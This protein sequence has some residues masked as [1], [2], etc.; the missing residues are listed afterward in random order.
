MGCNPAVPGA[1]ASH[2]HGVPVTQTYFF[3]PGSVYVE[4]MPPLHAGDYWADHYVPEWEESHP[5]SVWS[6]PRSVLFD[7]RPVATTGLSLIDCG[8]VKNSPVATVI[9][10]P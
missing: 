10:V 4:G 7:G 5:T 9:I 2:W 1:A 6:G 3:C 8:I